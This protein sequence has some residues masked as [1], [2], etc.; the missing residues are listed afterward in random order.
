MAEIT[1]GETACEQELCFAP[2]GTS[3]PVMTRVQYEIYNLP[4]F[5]FFN[6]ARSVTPLA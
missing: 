3:G 1:P 5:G 4:F 2:N 6:Q